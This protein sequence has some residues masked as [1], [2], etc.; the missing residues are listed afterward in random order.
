M[1]IDVLHPLDLSDGEIAAWTRLQGTRPEWASPFLSPHWPIALAMAGP[2]DSEQGRVAV[3]RGAHREPLGFFPARVRRFTALPPGAPLCDYQAMVCAPG[4]APDARDIVKAFGVGRIDMQNC[5]ADDA[6]FSGHLRAK[7][8]SLVVDLSMGYDAYAAAR[9]AAGSNILVDCAKKA[10][11]LEREHG[12]VVFTAANTDAS[13]LD[14]L[15]AWKRHQYRSTA[16]TDL[17]TRDW[18][19]SLLRALWKNATPAFGARLFTLHAGD[20]LVAA[21]LALTAPGVIHAWF[22]GHDDAFAKY[23]P[24]CSLINEILKWAPEHGYREMDLG[25]G[26]YRFKASLA[27]QRRAVGHGFVGRPSTAALLREA[28]YGVRSVVE[29][30]PLGKVSALPGK[31][32]RRMD[33]LRGLGA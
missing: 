19:L 26:D 12:K 25:P 2:P 16:Q 21:H 5:L 10:R 31:A 17:F 8:A 9:R 14:A 3:V 4:A 22:I 33:I 20:T 18:T 27:N 23:S 24:G 7:D 13:A 6:T 28:Q 11:K 30:L 32:M 1:T 15:I 29:G